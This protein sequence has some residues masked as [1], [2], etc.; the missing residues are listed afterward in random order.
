MDACMCRTKFSKKYLTERHLN[1]SQSTG[2]PILHNNF[3]I[4]IIMMTILHIWKI[5]RKIFSWKFPIGFTCLIRYIRLSVVLLLF[6]T[7]NI[8]AICKH[9]IY[10]REYVRYANN[11]LFALSYDVV[12]RH[13]LDISSIV[14]YTT[15]SNSDMPLR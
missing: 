3:I 12:Y 11:V 10:Q 14:N 7:Q 9:I 5:K 15:S 6:C 8:S 13:C 2:G 4:I 1:C